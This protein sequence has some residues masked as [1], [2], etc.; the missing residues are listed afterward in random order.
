MPKV[1]EAHVEARRRQILEAAFACFAARGFQRTTMREISR[2][3][4]LSSGA[5]YLYYESKEEM[6]RAL[7][8]LYGRE[9]KTLMDTTV[10]VKRD[11]GRAL[12]WGLCQALGGAGDARSEATARFDLNIWTEAVHND[13]LR[14]L[15]E[16][17]FDRIHIPLS[18][19]I[20]RGQQEGELNP[21]LDASA[22]A[23]VLIAITTGFVVQRIF[24]PNL[25]L[26]TFLAAA[27]S[28]LK[29]DFIQTEKS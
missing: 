8:D 7:A 9:K 15:M 23:S 29:G 5:V 19:L 21:G 22:A 17:S 14:R 24:N 4:G 1:S 28:L 16:E 27:G 2:K 12:A 11:F 13:D 3:A 20:R 10:R 18:E 25:E 26:E 6:V